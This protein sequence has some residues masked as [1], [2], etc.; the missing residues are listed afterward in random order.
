MYFDRVF[1]KENSKARLKGSDYWLAVAV[2]LVAGLIA[3]TVSGGSINY[4]S[5]LDSS[6]KEA[7]EQFLEER[8]SNVSHFATTGDVGSSLYPFLSILLIVVVVAA[9]FAWAYQ[10]FCGN[11][12]SVGTAGW[13]M[14]FA[15]GESP[16]FGTM[17]GAFKFY[18]RAMTTML[19]RSLYT[20]LWSLLFIVPGIIKGYAYSMTP[21][22]LCDNPNLTASQAI[23][24]SERMT[25]GY[26]GELFI[27]NLS[28]L[29]WNLLNALTLGILGIFYTDPYMRTAYAGAYLHLKQL[30]IQSGHLS[31]ADFG[32]PM[33]A[34][35]PEVGY[36][37]L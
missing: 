9:L 13:F 28:F 27:M 2:S 24:L 29:G 23:A 20:F 30:N 31:P 25:D 5:R 14:C 16:S 10:I 11:V 1:V 17:F 22:I 7:M 6:D 4:N 35:A 12:I 3:D 19:L 33:P 34:P 18:G 15:R 36:E 8:F 21:Y 32:D 26:K 37:A